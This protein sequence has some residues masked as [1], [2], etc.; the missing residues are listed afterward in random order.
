M[1]KLIVPIVIVC[2]SFGQLSAQD[3]TS[4]IGLRG[5]LWNGLTFK[6]F[7]G[8]STA[9][10]AILTTRWGGTILTGLIEK[11]NGFNEPGFSWFYGGGAHLGYWSSSVKVPGWAV[12]T[13][14]AILGV[15]GVIGLEYAIEAIPLTIQL[16]YILAL[17]LIPAVW[18]GGDLF[19]LSFRYYW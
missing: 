12:T 4:A 5:G 13:S 16:D 19:G 2:L 10:E 15:D 6:H 18:T 3:Y 7:M 14:T 1:K 8:G 11:H 9:I 17:N